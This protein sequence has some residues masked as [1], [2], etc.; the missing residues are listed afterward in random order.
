MNIAGNITEL[1]GH[2]PLVYLDRLNDGYARI[3]LKLE[4]RN[5]LAGLKDRTGHALI[6]DALRRGL[7]EPGGL[8][9]EASSGNTGLALAMVAAARGFRLILTMPDT[10]GPER[11]RLLAALGAELVL[12]PGAKGMKGAIAAAEEIG[13]RTYGAFLPRQ[14]SNPAG[15]EIHRTTTAEEIWRDTNGAVDVFIAGVGT[16][17]TISGVG[18]GLKEKK[19][20]VR[21]VAVEGAESAVLSG[22]PAGPRPAVPGRIPGLGAGFVPENFD[23]AVVDRIVAVGAEDA[24]RTARLLARTEGILAGASTGAN[25]W[26]A[27]EMSRSIENEGRLIVTVLADSGERYLS[28]WL[29]EE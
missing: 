18:R 15:P 25:L 13:A 6:D 2:T 5:P 26:T 29:F 14:F 17:A 7:L 9:V 23:S 1:I 19:S 20:A 16:G 22:R 28:T 12:S 3:A 24:G 21:I 4:S 27:L 8:I 10:V 11:R